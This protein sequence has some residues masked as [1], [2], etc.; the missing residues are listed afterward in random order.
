MVVS[1][2][3][4]NQAWNTLVIRKTARTNPALLQ[5]LLNKAHRMSEEDEDEIDPKE[6]GD[7]GLTEDEDGD[8]SGEWAEHGAM[9]TPLEEEPPSRMH[10]IPPHIGEDTYK[11]LD[12]NELLEAMAAGQ[13]TPAEGPVA[14]KPPSHEKPGDEDEEGAVPAPKL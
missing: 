2:Q 11:P 4:M 10:E 1:A 12:I 7:Y 13:S 14:V 6:F 3:A 5:Y 9:P 8:A